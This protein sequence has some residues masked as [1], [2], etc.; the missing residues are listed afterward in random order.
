MIPGNPLGELEKMVIE[1]YLDPQLRRDRKRF[2]VMFNPNQ[3]S[4][5]YEI[6]LQD[7][8]A[9]GETG[10]SQVSNH[11]P[12]QEM[13]FEFLFDGTGTAK[14]LIPGGTAVALPGVKQLK[15]RIEEGVHEMVQRFLEIT[16]Q[17][18]S[19]SHEPRY[20]ILNW[21]VL[22]F[23]CKLKSADVQYT[24]FKPDGKPLRA[25]VNATFVEH[26]PDDEK[27]S[28]NRR[29][30]PD[31]TRYRVVEEGDKLHELSSRIYN[32]PRY[33]VALARANKLNTLR[34]L[35]TGA[36]LRFPPLKNS[37]ES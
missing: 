7:R 17:S 36:A 25:K 35:D 13:S 9:A 27:E 2:T 26:N 8:S 32:D 37:P 15:D 21:G 28:R 10:A 31:L 33:H 20:L 4:R 22:H 24:L 5:R 34:R 18:Q 1:S 11:T 14:P 6:A 19:E 16:F 29:R 12:P 23:R 3:Y 30:S